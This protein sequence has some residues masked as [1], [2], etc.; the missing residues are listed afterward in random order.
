MTRKDYIKIADVLKPYLKILEYKSPWTTGIDTE[1]LIKDFS[2]MLGEDNP[3][4]DAKRFE[5]YIDSED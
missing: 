2:N 1:T 5:D 3:R 4:F